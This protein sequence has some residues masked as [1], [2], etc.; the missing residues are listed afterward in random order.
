MS[1]EKLTTDM[2]AADI[3]QLAFEV[4]NIA[5]TMTAL[6]ELLGVDKEELKKVAHAVFLEATQQA[7]NQEEERVKEEEEKPVLDLGGSGPSSHPRGAA[8][9]GGD[10]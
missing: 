9:F 6:I 8:F 2:L 4:N 7:N 3:R 10:N 1:E 5:I